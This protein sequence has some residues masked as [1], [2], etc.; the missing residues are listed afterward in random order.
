MLTAGSFVGRPSEV[1]VAE[2]AIFREN[3]ARRRSS[4]LSSTVGEGRR[5]SI[6][7]IVTG[8]FGKKGE[9]PK[10]VVTETMV[11]E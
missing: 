4:T 5:A 9:E 1:A 6:V 3:D 11:Q 7:K 2:Q 10:E 8:I